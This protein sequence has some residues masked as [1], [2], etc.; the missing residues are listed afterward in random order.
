MKLL[1]ERNN[2]RMF[3]HQ[4]SVHN[5]HSIQT[6]MYLV[7]CIPDT[8]YNMTLGTNGMGFFRQV[9]GNFFVEHGYK[10]ITV[11]PSFVKF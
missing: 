11:C 5:R 8:R 6:Y 1:V 7:F 3:E 4:H 2:V 10:S 9:V